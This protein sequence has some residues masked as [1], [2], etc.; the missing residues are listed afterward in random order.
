VARGNTPVETGAQIE[1]SGLTFGGGEG[2]GT[3][4]LADFCCPAYAS[5]II[6]EVYGK[7]NRSQRGSGTTTLRFTIRRDGSIDP[8]S[9]TVAETSGSTVLDR[10]SRAALTQVRLPPLPREYTEEILIVNLEFPY[11]S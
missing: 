11:G 7:W 2:G 4:S 9:I 6:S 8:G 1:G 3:T 5:R 10:N